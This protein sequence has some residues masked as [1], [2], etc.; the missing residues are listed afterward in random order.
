MGSACTLARLFDGIIKG[1]STT[2][3]TIIHAM[4]FDTSQLQ[5]NMQMICAGR[6]DAAAD[7]MELGKIAKLSHL[8]TSL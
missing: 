1:E 5:R 3:F 8:H 2:N 6:C 4:L 7:L